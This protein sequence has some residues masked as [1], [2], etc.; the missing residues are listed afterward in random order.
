MRIMFALKRYRKSLKLRL[1]A[2]LAV[3]VPAFVQFA[4][5]L[6]LRPSQDGGSFDYGVICTRYGLKTLGPDQADQAS[7]DTG[8]QNQK[9][10]S[11][12][13]P[14]CAS[15]S[16]GSNTALFRLPSLLDFGFESERVKANIVG[17]IRH[18]K[19]LRY[20]HTPRAPPMFRGIS[21]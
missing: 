16:L 20:A 19:P 12:Y 21:S 18:F 3:L 4:Q 9:T 15:F 8:N 1:F 6:P 13:C 2:V 17:D 11:Q 10:N 14:V 7:K 5:A